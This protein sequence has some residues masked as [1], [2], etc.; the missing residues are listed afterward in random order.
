MKF[1]FIKVSDKVKIRKE[2]FGGILFDMDTGWMRHKRLFTNELDTQDAHKLINKIAD[3]GV[4]QLA[5]GGGEPLM[6][7]DLEDIVHRAVR[8]DRILMEAIVDAYDEEE[9][10]MG[11]YYYLKD[12][13]KFPFMARCIQV[14][15]KSP[16][17]EGEQVV[18][19]QMAPEDECLHEM[20]VKIQWQERR[21]G[22]PLAQLHN[23]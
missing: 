11:W 10:A 5:I 16:L 2:H 21:F 14:M 22:I 12:K 17:R 8:E 15:T 23:L 9:R 4:F 6:R 18:V 20:Y 13:I 1:Q 3:S 7:N 19:V